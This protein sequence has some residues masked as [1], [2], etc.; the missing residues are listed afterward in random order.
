MGRSGAG[1]SALAKTLAPMLDAVHFC[2]DDARTSANKDIEPS[3]GD[4]VEQARRMAR[5]CDSVT[6]GGRFAIADF[7]CPT[8]E[9]REAFGPAFVVW[10]DR[11]EPD[12]V[13][14]QSFS[15]PTQYDMRV[16][17]WLA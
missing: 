15:S 10:V 4:P 14:D 5:Y 3:S 1:K 12:A 7:V 17:R 16:L 11:A 6:A 8:P 13:P 2:A 9:A